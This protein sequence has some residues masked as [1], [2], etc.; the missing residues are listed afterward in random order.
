MVLERNFTAFG[1][2][3]VEGRAVSEEVKNASRLKFSIFTVRPGTLFV[4]MRGELFGY[5]L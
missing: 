3:G 2:D 5:F 1:T 4:V